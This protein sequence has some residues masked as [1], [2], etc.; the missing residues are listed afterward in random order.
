VLDD[1]ALVPHL[2][3]PIPFPRVLCLVSSAAVA[4]VIPTPTVLRGDQNLIYM[5]GTSKFA[6]NG[7][8]FREKVAPFHF[9]PPE[10]TPLAESCAVL[11]LVLLRSP[12]TW[13][14]TPRSSATR[15]TSSA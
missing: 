6:I 15:T 5:T 1:R 14:S 8:N 7:T 10:A 2:N 12:W 4:T 3:L 13:C 11:L 9:R